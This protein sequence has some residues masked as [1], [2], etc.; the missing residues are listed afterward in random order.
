MLILLLL[1]LVLLLTGFGFAAHLLWIL[2]V[3]FFVF[4]LAGVA[5]GRGE[6]AG[7]H[8]FYRW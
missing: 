3:I 7:R 5:L 4:W 1:I 8:R 2:A 6:S